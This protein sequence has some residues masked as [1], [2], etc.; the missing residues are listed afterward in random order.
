M[1]VNAFGDGLRVEAILLF[2]IVCLL[3]WVFGPALWK[4][5]HGKSIEEVEQAA[6]CRNVRDGVW[7]D[8]H[9]SYKDECGGKDPP[10][11]NEELTK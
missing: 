9:K 5:G 4:W 11:F 3:A 8:F 10:K 1:D 2:I 7:P 6:Y